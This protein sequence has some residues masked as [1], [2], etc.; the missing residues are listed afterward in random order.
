MHKHRPIVPGLLLPHRAN[1][2]DDLH[3]LLEAPVEAE[4]RQ[5]VATVGEVQPVPCRRRVRQQQRDLAGVPIHNRLR[6]GVEDARLGETLA[7]PGEVALEVVRHQHGHAVGLLHDALQRLQLRVVD[8]LPRAA[9]VDVEGAVG[10][11]EALGHLDGRVDC[12]DTELGD[13]RESVALHV[14]VQRTRRR[15]QVDLNR[16]EDRLV[17]RQPRHGQADVLQRPLDLA[18]RVRHGLH[19]EPVIARAKPAV[20]KGA[21]GAAEALATVE[22]PRLAPQILQP[23][24]AG[25]AGQADE[26]RHLAVR[27]AAQCACALAALPDAEGLQARQLVGHDRLE[28]PRIA[29]RLDEPDEVVVVRR[30]DVRRRVKRRQTLLRRADDDGHS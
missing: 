9:L 19:A 17:H 20:L 21:E 22:E 6:I 8:F 14:L 16:V 3:V 7:Q 23:V 2:L 15:R 28:R 29:E 30:V 24:C 5:D 27:H 10:H 11:L 25:R 1:P 18:L 12:L 26:T 4:E 13:L